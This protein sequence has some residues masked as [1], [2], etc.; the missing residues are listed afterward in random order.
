MKTLFTPF[1]QHLYTLF[2][3]ATLLCFA[4]SLYAQVIK[5]A[6][7]TTAGT[8][9][10]VA[11]SYLSTVTNLTVTG[12]IDARDFKTMRDNMPVLAVLDLSTAIIIAYTGTAGTL[13]TNST[14]YLTN[15]MPTYSFYMS[16]ISVG[17]P[18]LKTV[19]LPSSVTSIGSYA[20]NGC[21]ALISITIPNSVIS[22]AVAAFYGCTGLTSITIPSSTTS[23]GDFAFYGCTGLTSITIPSSVTSIG[24]YDFYGCIG[25]T[26]ITIPSSVTSI[27]S[28]AFYGCSGLTSIYANPTTPVNFA[29]STSVFTGVSM[30]TCV[31][32][33]PIGSINAYKAATQWSSFTNITDGSPILVSIAPSAISSSTATSG[34]NITIAGTSSVTTRGVCWSTSINPTIIDSKTSDGAGIGVFTSLISGL[35]SGVTYH[36]RAYATNSVGTSYG[37]DLTFTTLSAPIVTTS[38]ASNITTTTVL[39]GG[40][41]TSAGTSS[42]TDRG[43]CW[44]TSINPTVIDSKTTDGTGI[45]IFSSSISGLTS[46]VTYHIRAYATNSVGTSYGTDLTFTTL[47]TTP[48]IT[49]TAASAVTATSAVTGGNVTSIGSSPIT[50]RGICWS[51]VANPTIADS[52]TSNGTGVGVYT[53]SITGLALGTSYHVRAYATSS[54]GTSYGSDVTF[55]TLSSSTQVYLNNIAFISLAQDGTQL[56]V[57]SS[58][59][60]NTTNPNNYV[61]PGNLVRFK[62]QCFNNKTNGTNIVSGSCKV[63]CKDPYIT[64]TDSTSGLNNVG[65]NASA[66][67]T[68]EFEIQILNTAPF[69]HVSYVDF[70]VTEGAN[71]Y[72]TYQIPILIAP[73]NLQ[74][75]TVDDDNNPD[76]HGNS[77]GI[78]EPNEIIE[79]L[80]TL[81]NVSSLSANS[82]SGTFGSYYGAASINVWNNKQG[83]SGTVVNNSYWNYAFG[84]PQVITAGAKDLLPQW[85]F[86]FDYN[87]TKTLHFKMGLAMSGSFN[88]FS[89]Y[90]SYFKWLIPIDYNVGYPEFNTA[91]S[92]N[93]ID[94]IDFYPNPTNG[95]ININIGSGNFADCLVNITNSL[96]QKVYNS[97]LYTE[98]TTLDLTKISKSGLLIIQ[99][100]NNKGAVIGEKKILVE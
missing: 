37:S 7:V 69:G 68:D 4:T 92:N 94:N 64:L 29:L 18:T 44:S 73:L 3:I 5:T 55:T 9:S 60:M 45:G 85:D 39:A 91:I 54:V 96:G 79:S 33:V 31:L 51:K 22:I 27:G 62:M 75:K 49:T 23:L 66:W 59:T 74:I 20:F 25:L 21:K 1:K 58:M 14:T 90:K 30:S 81:Q 100:I 28:Y 78:C 84:A 99:I 32:Y 13:G 72:Y 11:S 57:P 8:L 93:Y 98:K 65:W 63:R 42:V 95:I 43:V 50:A 34:G 16:S 38:T 46:G 71:S 2:I 83:S 48:T 36:I 80:P 53:S 89:G 61:N 88:L 70:I 26:S 6:N 41:I 19:I 82:V 77:N 40:N 52:I 10:T 86:V 47:G 35:T 24:S 56:N 12:T 17:K 67:S 76:S 15:E 97:K 87:Y